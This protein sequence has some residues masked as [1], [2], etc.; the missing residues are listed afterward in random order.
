[1]NGIVPSLKCVETAID[2]RIVID[3]VLIVKLN[4]LVGLCIL[5]AAH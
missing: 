1:L 5:H 2:A 3:A 4:G